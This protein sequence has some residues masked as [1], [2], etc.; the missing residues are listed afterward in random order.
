[1]TYC[2]S[3]IHGEYD[4]LRRLLELIKF[5]DSD[6]LIVAGDMIDKGPDSVKVIQMLRE[7]AN[8]ECVIGNHEYQF[9]KYYGSLMKSAT[10][11]HDT[12]LTKLRNYFP[13][14]KGLGWE[15]MDWLEE[16]PHYLE[17]DDF[18]VIHSG[19][20]RGSNHEFVSLKDA[21]IESCVY[22]RTFKEPSVIFP[23]DKCV[24]FGH[25]PTN[26]YRI[27]LYQ[28]DDCADDRCSIRAYSKIHI[29]TGVYLSNTLGCICVETLRTYY[30]HK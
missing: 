17:Y 29:D 22:D 4:L 5:G 21:S 26:D 23:G 15:D 18:A 9:M 25:T 11:D 30:V 13:G 14:E 1:M 6:T 8:T 27:H 19:W 16:L 24:I 3:D 2:V 20:P 12:V 28:R 7:M 10:G